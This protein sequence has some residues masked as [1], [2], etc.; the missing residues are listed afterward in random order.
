MRQ[1]QWL[2]S[3]TS[4]N[5]LCLHVNYR[6]ALVT[7]GAAMCSAYTVAKGTAGPL[8]VQMLHMQGTTL[9]KQ[10]RF[11]ALKRLD[12]VSLL[13]EIEFSG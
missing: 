3:K 4:L 5:G 2:T 6:L 13:N 12:N 1:K 8:H 10:A 9:A 7:P 11:H